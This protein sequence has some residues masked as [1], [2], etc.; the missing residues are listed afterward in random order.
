MDILENVNTNVSS[1]VTSSF[2]DFISSKVK[3]AVEKEKEK[4][5]KDLNMCE[6]EY[7]VFE[8]SNG[9]TEEDIELLKSPLELGYKMFNKNHPS[10]D[11]CVQH[12]KQKT[13]DGEI[14]DENRFKAKYEAMYEK[15]LSY[16]NTLTEY[17][18][19]I[20]GDN[21]FLI[22]MNGSNG[23]GITNKGIIYKNIPKANPYYLCKGFSRAD[24]ETQRASKRISEK[25]FEIEVYSSL[26]QQ[27]NVNQLYR[28]NM[29]ARD[30][31]AHHIPQ[32]TPQ[33][34]ILIPNDKLREER[35]RRIQD[36]YSK[37]YLYDISKFINMGNRKCMND[38]LCD[39]CCT[40]KKVPFHEGSGCRKG[41]FA[42]KHTNTI[43]YEEIVERGKVT[44]SNHGQPPR[45]TIKKTKTET[46]YTLEGEMNEVA[47]RRCI[48][49]DICPECGMGELL[50]TPEEIGFDPRVIN[51]YPLNKEYIDIL[52]LI[53]PENLETVFGIQTIYA[54][55]HPRANENFVIEEKLKKLNNLEEV[56]TDRV[57]QK[58]AEEKACLKKQKENYG[59]KIK[60]I[61]EEKLKKIF[62]MFILRNEKKNND[63]DKKT[64]REMINHT[65]E[66]CNQ[67]ETDFNVKMKKKKD[68]FEKEK[69]DFEK[70]K[71]EYRKKVS[72][73]IDIAND[74]NELNEEQDDTSC[75]S[76]DI[77]NIIKRLKD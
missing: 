10:L 22:H 64:I 73:L 19:K 44:K 20:I 49:N 17:P 42:V 39:G 65:K 37:Y 59:E 13:K 43:E 77:F 70:E 38:R 14:F 52:H 40:V 75:K 54:K 71:A 50:F 25:D 48:E 62:S 68:D 76:N 41:V 72:E 31:G 15:I 56:I 67:K 27:C 4:F 26:A 51:K 24:K 53:R 35:A 32:M 18:Q 30:P 33:E 1:M 9:L 12:A 57:S 6:E 61:N 23:Y 55:Y 3:G 29:Y 7:P 63:D 66:R 11:H 60:G 21:E 74:I 36:N 34:V 5:L 45:T 8:S 58:V 2:D 16:Y 28:A 47:A 69:D 46:T